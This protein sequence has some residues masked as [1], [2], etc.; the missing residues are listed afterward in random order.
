[1]KRAWLLIP[2][3]VSCGGSQES[4]SGEPTFS[5]GV[6]SLLHRSCATCHRPEGAAPFPLV[7][8]EQAREHGQRIARMTRDREMPPWRPS[9]PVGAFVDERRLTDEEIGLLQRWVEDGMPV[10]DPA[11]VPSPPTWGEEWALGAPDLVVEMDEAYVVPADV[12]EIF[13][14]FVL[15]VATDE[16]RW[17]RAVELRPG[18]PHVVHHATLVVDR[19]NAS[20]E[21]DGED[22]GPG[23][24]GMGS[25]GGAQ[26]P[27]GV[28]IGWTPGKSAMADSQGLMWQLH[29]GSDLVARLHLR[30]VDEPMEVRARVG[31]HFAEAPPDR[32][33]VAVQLGAQA[34]DIPAGEPA[35]EVRD[36]FPLPVDV[37]VLSLYPHAHYLGKR[38]EAW[39]ETP[40]GERVWLL[41]I[42]D[43][44]FNWQ[45]EYRF[46]EPVRLS[47]GT[48]IHMRYTYD[49]TSANSRN[50]IDP[51]ARVTYG[52]R[53]VDEMADL[54]VQTLPLSREGSMVLTQ[55]VD[56]KVAA[57]KLQGYRLAL[58][59]GHEDA[60]LRYNMGI[61][62]AA[63]GRLV[64]A[65]A[66]LRR[67]TALDPSFAEA[68]INLGIVL[69][70]QGRVPEALAAYERAVELAPEEPRARHNAGMALQELG[71]T[72][73]A[74]RSFREA[75]EHD[76]TFALSHKRLGR[77][78]ES[79]GD[80]PGALVSYRL[81]TQHG[82]EDAE[83]RM[84]LGHALAATGDGVGGLEH[85]RAASELAPDWPQPLLAMADLLAGYPNP[86]VRQPNEAAR[87][88]R[89]AVELTRRRDPSALLT[90]ANALASSGDLGQA[91]ATAEEALAMARQSGPAGLVQATEAFLARLRQSGR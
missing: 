73:D 13:R 82:P 77:L 22:P 25:A 71:R 57:I 2:L 14:N 43:W 80:L 32:L 51:P 78:L 10:G 54:I 26:H 55:A 49:N 59:Q 45:D 85:F 35:Y 4:Q 70:Q 68:F 47:A 65:E 72:P 28:F 91:I 3:L 11:A 62:E 88:A 61:A 67:S 29:P 69:H 18:A 37:D 20:R 42:P 31:L 63:R 15:P 87:L 19:T 16:P 17:I 9:R 21:L 50:P 75:I 66:H 12:E 90:L 48:T 23:F 41:E 81:A 89:R 44:D 36:S 58:E 7:T 38:V 1:M 24:D 79:R 39:A 33:P 60:T 76:P 64:D 56:R 40:G 27:G 83:T 53:S 5:G 46:R 30:P 74:E 34:I 6:A 84:W 86:A 8:Y 52:P